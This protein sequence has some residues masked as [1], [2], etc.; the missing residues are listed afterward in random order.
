LAEPL[1]LPGALS[2]VHSSLFA[3]DGFPHSEIHGS[4]L[5]RSSPWLIA[6]YHVLHRLSA[7]RHPP[8]ALLS[9]DRS[10]YQ[11]PSLTAVLAARPGRS[12]LHPNRSPYLTELHE[13][14]SRSHMIGQLGRPITSKDLS[15]HTRHAFDT[16]AVKRG[17]P[18]PR[19]S[20]RH[21]RRPRSLGDCR[22]CHPACLLFT[23]TSEQDS[24][25]P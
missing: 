23:I 5:V 6:A 3:E 19:G 20:A 9:L 25:R 2:T 4:K 12:H 16:P 7:P 10:H 22:S 18:D 14:R 13:H 21:K 1:S 15:N 24:H 17:R 8:D 11:C